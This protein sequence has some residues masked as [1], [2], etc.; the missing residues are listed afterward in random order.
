VSIKSR[1]IVLLERELTG[2]IHPALLKMLVR[3]AEDHNAM[4]QQI[5]TLA[6]LM[7]RMADNQSHTI[8][9]T[10]Q[11]QSALPLHKRAK[12]LAIRVG[13]DPTLTGEGDE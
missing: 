4:K 1:D 7:D 13:S 10:K 3:I 8:M 5:M 11:L 2:Q 9:A 6:S 12:E